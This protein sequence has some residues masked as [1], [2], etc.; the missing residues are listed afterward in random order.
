MF[1]VATTENERILLILAVIMQN[2]FHF[3]NKDR[4]NAFLATE[5]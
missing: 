1:E 4:R 2:S 5:E 3:K